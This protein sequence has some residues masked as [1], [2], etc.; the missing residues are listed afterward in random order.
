VAEARA[1]LV[2]GGHEIP[3]GQSR[4]VDLPLARVPATHLKLAMSVDVIHGA[5]PG[6]SVWISSTIHGDELNGIEIVRQVR[7]TLAPGTLRGTVLCV[8]IVNIFGFVHQSRYLPDRRDL[9]RSFPGS[10]RGSLAAR[11]AHTFMREVVEQC[12]YGIDLH[13]GSDH[14]RNLPQIRANL[15][16]PETRRIALAFGAPVTVDARTRDGSLRDAASRRG[17]HVL[18][19]EAGEADR[20]NRDAVRG[21][22]QGTRRVLADLGLVDL[23]ERENGPHPPTVVAVKTQWVR[24]RASG[25]V[26]LQVGLGD[27]V[28]RSTR[29]GY[30]SDAFGDMNVAV[31]APADGV[32][33]GRTGHPLVRRGDA[34]LNLAVEFKSTDGGQDASVG[35]NFRHG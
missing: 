9:N 1:A 24:A 19:Y 26:R 30:I 10:P 14:R 15:D 17:R 35:V 2:V 6:P 33:I 27:R 31:T 5:H 3:A 32:V 29:I 4:R 22:V 18:L 20:F 16:D 11:V 34:L 8:P 21:G 28:Q 25:L 23:D 7:R 12:D 13:T